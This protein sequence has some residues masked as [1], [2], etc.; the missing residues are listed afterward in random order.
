[1]KFPGADT[2]EWRNGRSDGRFFVCDVAITG[3]IRF[4]AS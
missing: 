4:F 2:R 1:M 3:S